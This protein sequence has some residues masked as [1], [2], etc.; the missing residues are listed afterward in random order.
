MNRRWFF[1]GLFV[2]TLG[3]IVAIALWD[4]GPDWD[5]AD[6]RVEVV[7]V[8]D[9]DGNAIEDG[10]TIVVEGGR[11]GFPFGLLLIP[12]FLLLVFGLLRWTFWGPPGGGPWSPPPDDRAREQWLAEWHARQHQRLDGTGTVTPPEGTGQA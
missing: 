5:R 2:L 6:R 9:A 3:A 8:V 7:R 12:L 10:S 1:A 11:H 4:P